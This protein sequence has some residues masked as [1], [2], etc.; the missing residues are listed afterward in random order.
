V[1]CLKALAINPSSSDAW[2]NRGVI[3]SNLG[4]FQSSIADFDKAIFLNPGNAAAYANKGKALA[5]LELGEEARAAYAQAIAMSPNLP[6]GS[7]GLGQVLSQLGQDNEAIGADMSQGAPRKARLAGGA[8]PSP[9]ELEP[10]GVA[11]SRPMGSS[12]TDRGSS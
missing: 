4:D 3:S 1:I 9:R 12:K 6:E 7:L 10:A 11:A 2:N 8:P 5:Q